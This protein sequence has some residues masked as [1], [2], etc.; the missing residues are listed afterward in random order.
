MRS[1]IFILVLAACGHSATGPG[2]D[3]DTNTSP[4]AGPASRCVMTPSAP[5]D[6]TVVV[7]EAGEVRGAQNAT[8]RSF[9]GIPYAAPPVGDLRFHAT[10]QAACWQGVRDA[11]AFGN[12][13]PQMLA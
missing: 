3:D 13:C 8:T 10:E 5:D 12:V 1:T 9:L 11:T 7:T 6:P 2:G 4:D